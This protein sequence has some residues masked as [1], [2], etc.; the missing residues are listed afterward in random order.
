MDGEG[1]NAQEPDKADNWN[2]GEASE[3]HLEVR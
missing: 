1:Q 2:G 3:L